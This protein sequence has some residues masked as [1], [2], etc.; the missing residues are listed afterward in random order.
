MGFDVELDVEFAVGALFGR[1][2]ERAIRKNRDLLEE[3]LE[4]VF[5]VQFRTTQCAKTTKLG[6]TLRVRR[7]SLR[8]SDLGR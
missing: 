3:V 8:S 4:Q 7:L 1:G 5:L 2:V 6:G